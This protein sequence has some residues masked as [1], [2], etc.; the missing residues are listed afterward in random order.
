VAPDANPPGW[1]ED[2]RLAPLVRRAVAAARVVDPLT[3]AALGE[4]VGL[5]LAGRDEELAQMEEMERLAGELEAL[6]TRPGTADELDRVALVF[7]LRRASAASAIG[8]PLG[9][10]TLER[11]LLARLSQLAL[12]APG[13]VESLGELVAAGPRVL[14]LSRAGGGDGSASSGQ[15]AL[16]AARRLPALL[17]AC[18]GAVGSLPVAAAVRLEVE[19]ALGKLLQAAAEDTGWLLKEYLPA[20]GP[21]PPPTLPDPLWAGLGFS[22]DELEAEAEGALAAAVGELAEA[23]PG[24]ALPE[25]GLP[26][27]ASEVI[28]EWTAASERV[29]GRFGLSASWGIAVREAPAWLRS[30][31][32]PLALI[33]RAPNDRETAL[34]LVANQRR[35]SLSE[36]VEDLYCRDYLPAASAW[37]GFRVA[38]ALL[39]APELAE[40]W[41]VFAAR[42]QRGA[43]EL[44]WRAALALGAIAMSRHRAGVDQAAEMIVAEAGLPLDQARLQAMQVAERPLAALTFL[45]GRRL[46]LQGSA[47]AGEPG[48]ARWLAE[49]PLP[50]VALRAIG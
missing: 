16:E 48:V 24:T 31:L 40:G 30:L 20:A 6:G 26:A 39:P 18:A 13:A 42:G 44:A 19:A 46:L 23:A 45:A 38:R 33:M 34:L 11:H 37:A 5:P 35:S 29:M 32:P 14:A 7:G 1:P 49:G 25:P 8:G 10:R 27:S 47:G 21:A 3:L 12:G 41:R 50:G 4:A 43:G 2:A 15:L 36:G 9:A 22:L 28:R 17:D